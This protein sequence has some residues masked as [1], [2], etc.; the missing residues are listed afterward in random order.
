[1]LRTKG[2]K[3][4]G[5]TQLSDI[6]YAYNGVNVT[7]RTDTDGTVTSFGYDDS[8]QLTSESRDNS[9]S[10]G[11]SISLICNHNENRTSKVLNSVTDTYSYDNHDKLTATME[12]ARE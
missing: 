4:S 6:Q 3:N 9:H 2:T 12:R 8:N 1:L 11:Y 5:G 7:S 10:T